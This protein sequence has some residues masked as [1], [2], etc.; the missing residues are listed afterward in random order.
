[1]TIFLFLQITISEQVRADAFFIL[2]VKNT[3]HAAMSMKS[4][5]FEGK[6]GVI[7]FL[8]VPQKPQNRLHG[9]TGFLDDRHDDND[10]VPEN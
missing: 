5:A 7:V 4:A 2:L 8:G 9:L 3:C 6:N 1:M 10:L